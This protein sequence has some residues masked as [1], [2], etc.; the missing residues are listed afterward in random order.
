MTRVWETLSQTFRDAWSDDSTRVGVIV[1]CSGGADS[2][3]LFRLMMERYQQRHSSP[4]QPNATL[5]IAH[6]N[7]Q[8][9]AEQ[10][11]R[12]ESFVRELGQRWDVAVHVGRPAKSPTSDAEADLRQM[13]RDFFGD[14]ASQ[15]GCR[16]IALAHTAD[17]Q[18]E[19]ILHHLVRGSGPAGLTGMSDASPL[20]SDF[21]IRRPLLLSAR[22][23]IRQALTEIGQPWREDASNDDTRYTRNWLRHTILPLIGERFPKSGEAIRRAA[24]VQSQHGEFLN[25]LAEQWIDAFVVDPPGETDRASEHSCR[26]MIEFIRPGPI[27]GSTSVPSRSPNARSCTAGGLP[28]W[29]HHNDLANE[30]PIITAACQRV[31]AL[32]GWSRGEMTHGHWRRLARAIATAPIDQERTRDEREMLVK[33]ET[34]LTGR[35][36]VSLGHWPGGIEAIQTASTLTLHHREIPT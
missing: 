23:T 5:L 6:F 2:V 18:V 34:R 27:A 32:L 11:D 8:L 20:G 36:R 24:E 10:S 35:R 4:D 19:T 15:T 16:Y 9:R 13:R 33:I 22:A 1:G 26:S 14:L 12:D 28:A 29:S 3:A 17:D 25:R 7:H 31:F 30:L 21:V